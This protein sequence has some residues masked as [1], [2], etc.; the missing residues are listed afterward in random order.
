[1]KKT[2]IETQRS[3]RNAAYILAVAACVFIVCGCGGPTAES[4][5]PAAAILGDWEIKMTFRQREI[6][7]TLSFA[8]GPDGALTGTW[9]SRRGESELSDIAFDGDKLT[10]SRKRTYRGQE[11]TSIYEAVVQGAKMTGKT[12]TRRGDIAFQGTRLDVSGD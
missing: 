12:T 8:E 3:C 6:T 2:R 5:N 4:A 11:R 1:M 9:K 7:S 10:F